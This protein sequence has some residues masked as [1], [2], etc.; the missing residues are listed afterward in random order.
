[1][2]DPGDLIGLPKID[3]TSQKTE[4]LP[5]QWFPLDNKPLCIFLDELNRAR[6]EILLAV[7]DFSLNRKLAIKNLPEGSFIIS[8]VNS[9][10]DYQV[11]DLDSALI[12]RFNIYTLLGNIINV[13]AG[14]SFLTDGKIDAA[15]L[16]P[17]CYYPIAHNYNV[18]CDVVGKGFADGKAIG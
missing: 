1:M 4:F 17:I 5:P 12:S 2:S 18:L 6:P 10:E 14:E 16:K 7:M 8:A 15:K 13:S 9:G 11:T 3:E